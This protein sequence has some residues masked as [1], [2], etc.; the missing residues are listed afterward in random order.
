MK[1][2]DTSLKEGTITAFT[3]DITLV[4][5]CVYDL[6]AED[7]DGKGASIKSITPYLLDEDVGYIRNIDGSSFQL[8]CDG[9]DKSSSSMKVRVGRT[10]IERSFEINLTDIS[11]SRIEE[12]LDLNV[13]DEKIISLEADE[14][15]HKY[16]IIVDSPS[17]NKE[18]YFSLNAET[19]D[20]DAFFDET[21]YNYK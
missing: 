20:E 21:I 14:A 4:R 10:S 18:L 2:Q 13:D 11:S 15:D 3:G 12:D 19:I 17:N 5:G 7:A 1:S 16:N 9:K 8:V 6:S